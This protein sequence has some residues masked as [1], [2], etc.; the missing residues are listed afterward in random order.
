MHNYAWPHALCKSHVDPLLAYL[1]FSIYLF[2]IYL[3]VSAQLVT[4]LETEKKKDHK[5]HIAAG[6]KP[7]RMHHAWWS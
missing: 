3:C 1:Y 6:E 5:H 2:Y 4:Q 7:E